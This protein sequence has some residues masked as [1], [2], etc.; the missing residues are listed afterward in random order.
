MAL[1]NWRARRNAYA[2]W[3]VIGLL[4]SL[5]GDVALIWPSRYFVAGLV[6]F[7]FTHIT[8]LVAFTRDTKFLARPFIWIIYVVIA[9][10]FYA[11]LFPNLPSNLRLPVA[12][13]AIL[14]SSMAAQAMIRS[15]FIKTSASCRAAVGA[16]FFMLSDLLLSFDRFHTALLL[17]PVLILVPYYAGQWLIASSTSD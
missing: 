3:I 6:A 9:A 16:I 11:L 2:L 7:L 14:L 10:T 12:V 4:F 15:L 1:S 5:C 8:Y 13:Y 17:A